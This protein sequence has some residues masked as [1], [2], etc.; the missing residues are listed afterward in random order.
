MNNNISW[1][2]EECYQN[3]GSI[4]NFKQQWD[5]IRKFLASNPVFIK[6][7][8]HQKEALRQLM[9]LKEHLDHEE[10]FSVYQKL[11]H[12]HNVISNIFGTYELQASLSM[13][14]DTMKKISISNGYW[15]IQY[16]LEHPDLS[17]DNSESFFKFLADFSVLPLHDL[18]GFST[19]EYPT[20]Q[21]LY[22][23]Q[24]I[25]DIHD[26]MSQKAFEMREEIRKSCYFAC[27]TD[28]KE[29]LK[30]ILYQLKM[31]KS[32][33]AK[34]YQEDY[35]KICLALLRRLE[36]KKRKRTVSNNFEYW[37]SLY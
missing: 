18:L 28:K 36:Q 31:D 5:S 8:V 4:K 10:F 2:I 16:L 9:F 35:I 7:L 32:S 15:K 12:L 27:T 22:D 1:I 21:M 33:Y 23:N 20:L 13:L 11:H 14:L 37:G 17:F 34:F 3:F 24:N 19:N 6:E 26:F 29:Q 30:K 25:F